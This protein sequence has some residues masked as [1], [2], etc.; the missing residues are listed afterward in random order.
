MRELLLERSGGNPF[1]LEELA[2]LLAESGVL[3]ATPRGA[4]PVLP[5]TLRGLVAARLDALPVDA[6]SACSRTPPCSAGAARSPPSRRMAEARGSPAGPA[7]ALERRWSP[8]TSSSWTT[9]QCELRAPTWCGRSPTARS[10][11]PS[12]PA[13]TPRLAC[14]LEG[15]ATEK[16]RADELLEE[17][18]R[19]YAAAAELVAEVGAVDGVPDDV[20]DRALDALQR[21]AERAEDRETHADVGPP[22]RPAAP[23]RSGD[24]PGPVRRHA[25]IGR[26]RARTSL[27]QLDLARAD[28]EAAMEESRAAG[29]DVAVARAL[30]V[31]GDLERNEGDFDA[32]MATLGRGPGSSG[33]RL[34][35]RR[36]EA[37]A[38]RRQGLTHLFA[39]DLDAGRGRPARGARRLLRRSGDRKGVAWANQNLAWIAFYRGEQ[40]V[41]EA[42]LNDSIALFADIGDWGGLGW[43]LGLMAWVQYAQGHRA[44]GRAP[45]RADD[46]RGTGAGRPLGRRP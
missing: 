19:H 30:T 10:P 32:S 38:L 21:A 34:G 43:S 31:R 28:L 40:D 37:G 17:L 20:R 4:V 27:R 13:A 33:A 42:R 6:A 46:A 11:R 5:A 36:G 26:A 15:R 35:D 23:P 24:E 3:A 14:W 39:G 9:A 8:R 22:L 16:E 25:L 44:R 29:D 7:Q 41:A 45:R 12:G 1:F 18:A 2:G